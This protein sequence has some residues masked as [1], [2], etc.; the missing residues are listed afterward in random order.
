MVCCDILLLSLRKKRIHECLGAI[1]VFF[2]IFSIGDTV[3]Q[4]ISSTPESNMKTDSPFLVTITSLDDVIIEGPD[5]GA[6][7]QFSVLTMHFRVRNETGKELWLDQMR[8]TC[9]CGSNQTIKEPL[10]VG[11][12]RLL[13]VEYDVQDNIGWREDFILIVLRAPDYTTLRLRIGFNAQ[14]LYVANPAN[15]LDLLAG[16]P[17]QFNL[18][19][20]NGNIMNIQELRYDD[21]LLEVKEIER[22]PDIEEH[23]F[24]IRSAK[25]I[26]FSETKTS[27]AFTMTDGT[28]FRLPVIVRPNAEVVM[29]PAKHYLL[30][31][32]NEKEK[33]HEIRLTWHV[34]LALE[35]VISSNR[36]VRCEILE[37]GL[38]GATLSC[39]VSAPEGEVGYEAELRVILG[40]DGHGNQEYHIR[41]PVVKRR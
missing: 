41:I 28:R 7:P 1:I 2:G 3:G 31:D 11:A 37:S 23:I 29:L 6:I 24:S 40:A 30:F 17:S 27:V 4:E 34:P 18:R 35:E 14:P 8:F 13:L 9:S 10:A 38:A 19:R 15:R 12:E 25:P 26:A 16:T 21:L 39:E 5:F 22:K 36:A 33:I 32:E 20:L